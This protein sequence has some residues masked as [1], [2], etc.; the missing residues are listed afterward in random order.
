MLTRRISAEVRPC[1]SQETASESTLQEVIVTG[2]RQGGLE[3]AESPAPIQIVTSTQLTE[4]GKPDLMS[5]LANLVPSFV[6]Q[7]FGSNLENQTIQAKL[8]VF[9]VFLMVDVE[10][11]RTV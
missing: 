7:A 4:S 8:R 6:M 9:R 5:A 3:A 11:L 2:T 1:S 10:V